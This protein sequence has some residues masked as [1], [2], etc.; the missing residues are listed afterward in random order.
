MRLKKL[1]FALLAILVTLVFLNFI[2]MS[3]FLY[4]LP[5]KSKDKVSNEIKEEYFEKTIHDQDEINHDSRPIINTFDYKYILRPSES[6]CKIKTNLLMIAMVTVSPVNFNQ[7]SVIRST[8]ATTHNQMEEN[9]RVVFIIGQ[10]LKS[11]INNAIQLEH[12]QNGDIVQLDFFDSYYN[13]TTKTIMGFR[14]VSTYCS[15]AR[16][17]LKIDDDVVVNLK[18]FLGYLNRISKDQ[19]YQTNKMMCRYSARQAPIR[20]SKSKY[21]ISVKEFSK[22]VFDPFCLG[23]AYLLTSDLNERFYH[24]ALF[25]SIFKLEDVY[26]GVRVF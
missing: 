18:S 24:L 9:F 15:N 2:F 14:W 11:E 16:Y 25:T 5:I 26:V 12:K 20:N 7:R 21:Y 8:W 13:L 23:P 6:F 17:T 4:K 19:N 22:K 1:I 10:S 3:I